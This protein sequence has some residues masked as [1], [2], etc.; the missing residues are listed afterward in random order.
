MEFS[1]RYSV[2][3]G[4]GGTAV[5]L[6]LKHRGPGGRLL[7][8]AN[9]CYAALY[10]ALYAGWSVAFCDVDPATGNLTLPLLQGALGK[11]RPDGV[12]LPHMYGQPIRGLA[13]MVQLCRSRGIFTIED[14]A[15]AMGADSPEYPVGKTGDYTL[16]STG[17]AKIVE[18]GYGGILASETDP[19]D[20]VPALEESL[21]FYGPAVEQTETLFSRLYRVLRNEGEG[22]LERVVYRA[23]PEGARRMFLFRLTEGQKRQMAGALKGLPGELNRRRAC[24]A[25]CEK[26]LEEAG[27]LAPRGPLRL[28]PYREGAVPWR[29]SFFVPAAWRRQL[30]DA[31]LG[32]GLPVSDWYPRITPLFGDEGEYPGAKEMEQTILNL[33]LRPDTAARLCPALARLAKKCAR[34]KEVTDP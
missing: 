19:L 25:D 10:P 24:L 33:P 1:P 5:Y 4:R 8:P 26:A 14:C 2:F 9:L 17:Y 18:V 21:P 28:Y 30:I 16:Y 13:D 32:E 20:W 22:V 7:A 29:L 11:H 27:A 3:T 23:L 34:D 15:S 31:C 12:I 6:L